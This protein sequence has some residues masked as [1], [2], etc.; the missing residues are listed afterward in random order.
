MTEGS[1]RRYVR[2]IEND[3]TILDG[4]LSLDYGFLPRT[5]PL[6]HLPK[7]FRPWDELAAQLPALNTSASARAALISL[8]LLDADGLPDHCLPRAATIL[9]Q[10]ALSWWRGEPERFFSLRMASVD[11]A[12]PDSIFRPWQQVTRRLGRGD[13][14]YQSGY[15]LFLNNFRP[16]VLDYRPADL[17]IETVEPLVPSFG[18]Q[19]ERVFYMAFVEMMGHCAPLIE[20]VCRIEEAMAEFDAA[21]V[22]ALLDAV[23]G[24]MD[25]CTATFRRVSPRQ[26]SA[27]WCDPL[28]WAKT[29]AILA[30]LPHP[31]RQGGTSG[32]FVP[33]FLTL[34]ALLGRTA[35]ESYYGS[36]LTDHAP[37]LLPPHLLEFNRRV[38]ALDLRG[39]L[40]QGRGRPGFDAAAH[41]Y[42]R[43]VDAY[44]GDTGY[45]GRHV[46][47][48]LNYL[49][50]AT[51]VGRNQSTSGDERF[52]HQHTW[53]EVATHLNAA[54]Q[55]RFQL[56]LAPAA[57]TTRPRP[58]PHTGDLPV[59]NAVAVAAS[60]LT[61][62]PLHVIDGLVYDLNAYVT[63]HPGGAD[64]IALYA[65]L[66]A[67]PFFSLGAE[68]A[69]PGIAE[70]MRRYAVARQGEGLG[71]AGQPL[72]T[73]VYARNILL[74]HKASLDRPD[75]TPDQRNYFA[76]HAHMQFLHEHL[77][78]IRSTGG[79]LPISLGEPEEDFRQGSPARLDED[80][81]LLESVIEHTI[82]RLAV[83]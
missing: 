6:D 55:E 73:A 81:A 62:R 68:H 7:A 72:A 16:L 76:M 50:V 34:D 44:A 66:D 30:V 70:Q 19:P 49:A 63:R 75:T 28:L 67:T 24:T 48:V 41:A 29:V 8:P 59:M 37:G 3:S 38:A 64:I 32:S 40:R 21:A 51:I 11:P 26:G 56:R 17:T 36:Y 79:T 43:V 5:P 58:A 53:V 31:W 22:A 74:R 77:P 14:P 45:L 69:S 46:S 80:I 82:E 47:K 25:K 42:D 2:M 39:W 54:R 18:N 78:A 20:T 65:G 1:L 23:A 10:L 27:T 57:A 33:V 83:A 4:A 52:T 9:S 71:A 12:L 60:S 35:Y 61:E 15:D 13:Q